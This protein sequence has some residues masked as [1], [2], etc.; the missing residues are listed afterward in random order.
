MPDG[1]DKKKWWHWG[2]TPPGEVPMSER[3]TFR[4]WYA[5]RQGLKWWHGAAALTPSYDINDPYYQEWLSLGKPTAAEWSETKATERYLTTPWGKRPTTGRAEVLK[6]PEAEA[7]GL[8]PAATKGYEWKFTWDPTVLTETGEPGGQWT[9]EPIAAPEGPTELTTEEELYLERQNAEIREIN[10]RIK[11][12]EK[13]LEDPGLTEYQRAWLEQQKAGFEFEK[14]LRMQLLGDR[15]L[16][17][18]FDEWLATEQLGE[19]KR[20]GEFERWL[21]TQ[22]LND[23]RLA[24]GFNEWLAKEN[25]AETKA[26]RAF[27]EWLAKE[28]LGET[29]LSREQQAT[30]ERERMGEARQARTQQA[31]IERERILA[32]LTGPRDWIQYWTY[33]NVTMPQA[34]AAE[35]REQASNLLRG[36][37]GLPAGHWEEGKGGRHFVVPPGAEERTQAEMK[38]MRLEEEAENIMRRTAGLAPPS[39]EWLPEHLIGEEVPTTGKPIR[40]LPVRTPSPQLFG[41]M[42]PT[43]QL[44]LAGYADWAAPTSR[45]WEDIAG[46]YGK[47]LPEEVPGA[48]FPQWQPI[49]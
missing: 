38:V 15:R 20:S 9:Q 39:P 33:R 6:D 1:K 34:R 24:R 21:Q 29:R 3:K 46:H 14:W 41:G 45:T 40:Q 48:R 36:V 18:G 10:A 13:S 16:A 4:E 11:A 19:T 44:G 8:L 37:Q 32:G 49:R 26:G 12:I 35:L 2:W 25:L 7:K 42:A 22:L 17:R 27:Q 47:M 43:A 30:L 5:A 23:R 31:G 28:Q